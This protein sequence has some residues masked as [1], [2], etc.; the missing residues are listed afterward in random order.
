MYQLIKI[1]YILNIYRVMASLIKYDNTNYK[2]FIK[3]KLSK[4]D[5]NHYNYKF[6][7]TYIYNVINYLNNI[8]NINNLQNINIEHVSS[9]YKFFTDLTFLKNTI[10][11]V[12]QNGIIKGKI[13]DLNNNYI[14]TLEKIY[15]IKDKNAEDN[16]N[17]IN[18]YH[19]QKEN[20]DKI[21]KDFLLNSY[22]ENK[23]KIIITYLIN[24]LIELNKI[25]KIFYEKLNETEKEEYIPGF[26]NNNKETYYN[27]KLFENIDNDYNENNEPLPTIS[28][29]SDNTTFNL[30]TTSPLK[31]EDSEELISKNFLKEVESMFSRP[32][33]P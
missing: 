32:R 20:Y 14:D 16:I 17:S 24:I 21:K 28:T 29:V 7:N 18:I 22:D 26:Y 30:S 15:N 23:S 4:D 5:T 19:R 27:I 1:I 3:Y 25:H 33:R 6:L 12:I 8:N 10:I 2:D 13:D 9:I 11:N 31:S